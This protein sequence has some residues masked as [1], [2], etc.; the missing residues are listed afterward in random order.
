MLTFY[1]KYRYILAVAVLSFSSMASATSLRISAKQ[2]PNEPAR[3]EVLQFETGDW[4]LKLWVPEHRLPANNDNTLHHKRNLD[5][6]ATYRNT[7]EQF[8]LDLAE[9][10]SYYLASGTH[11]FSLFRRYPEGDSE[12]DQ[13]IYDFCIVPRDKKDKRRLHCKSMHVN[14][15]KADFLK[16]LTQQGVDYE[17]VSATRADRRFAFDAMTIESER[18]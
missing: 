14:I 15:S 17:M 6:L 13:V 4:G 8:P 18:N 1:K 16:L 2:M 7:P 11:H 9:V 12:L 5:E 3:V 10:V